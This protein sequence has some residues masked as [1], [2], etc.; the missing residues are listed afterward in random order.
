MTAG[1]VA[2]AAPGRLA[3]DSMIWTELANGVQVMSEHIPG[4]RSA[5]VGVWVRQGSAHEAEADTG[6]S[7]MLEHMVFKGTERRTAAEIAVALEGL[8]GSLDAYTSR[9]HTSY[10]ARVLDEH[11]PEALDVLA[12][13]VLAPRLEASDLELEREVVL[14][15]IAQVEDTPDDLVFELHGER[16]WNGHPYGRSILGTKESVGA[17]T[18]ERLRELHALRYSGA[19]FLVAAAGNVQHEEFFERALQLFGGV[20]PGA[21]RGSIEPPR[22][23]L[24]GVEHCTRGS[25]QTHIVF[26]T[27]VPR[28]SHADR[29]A[30]VLL[31][32]ALGGGMSSRL[33]QRVRE[34]L[35]LCYSVFTYQSFYSLSGVGGVYV[36]T[37]PATADAAAAAVREELAKV[38]VDGLPEPELAQVKRQVKGQ[39]VLSLES[40][41][42][43]L[44]RLA[45]F[46][47]HD[48]P[49]LSLGE[50][51]D[52]VDAVSADDVRRVARTYFPPERQLELRLGPE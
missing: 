48:E 45:S 3:S 31:S 28:H 16:L 43:R 20:A 5:A 8:G 33:F 14:E 46:A 25:A 4:V 27:D 38:A 47:L 12:D 51:L 39:L 19:S 40:S 29:Y 41:G 17:M 24:S 30:L 1:K 15:E 9:E 34:E 49:L 44:Y 36:G 26:G 23:T 7:H 32:S 42:S 10:Q 50:L 35:G 52:K 37:R 21:G 11:L 22:P 2:L 18:A 13:L 6:V